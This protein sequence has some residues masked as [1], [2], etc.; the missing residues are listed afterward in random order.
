M[1]K[2]P[3][4]PEYGWLMLKG[5][6]QAVPDIVRILGPYVL[7]FGIFL[8]VKRRYLNDRA[9]SLGARVRRSVV[10][11][12]KRGSN[13][14]QVLAANQCVVCAKG[15]SRKVEEYCRARPERFGGM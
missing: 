10:R 15:V 4:D 7:L 14:V 12:E 3:P 2:S 6:L 13:R 8:W 5:M 9:P 11:E 1:P